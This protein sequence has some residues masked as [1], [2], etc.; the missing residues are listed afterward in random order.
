MNEL[1]TFAVK[2]EDP[3]PE[4]PGYVELHVSV[5][6]TEVEVFRCKTY[7][8]N[9]EAVKKVAFALRGKFPITMPGH[10]ERDNYKQEVKWPEHLGKEK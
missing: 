4:K 3:T 6:E 5:K 9:H 2:G 7:L 1:Y 8:H 10:F